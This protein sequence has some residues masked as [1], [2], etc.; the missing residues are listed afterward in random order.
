VRVAHAVVGVVVGGGW[1]ALPVMTVGAGDPVPAAPDRPVASSA[2]P[3][4][5]GTSAT[6]LLLPIAVVGAAGVLA[7]YGYVRRTRRARTRTTPGLV[8]TAPPVH[9]PADSERQAGAALVLADDCVRG[10]RE[11]LSFVEGLFGEERA[12]PFR[13]A[14]RAAETELAAAFAIWGRYEEG[15]PGDASARRQALVGVVGRCTEAGRRLDSEAEALDRLRDLEEGVGEALG[16]AEGR[17]RELTARTAA[18]QL[19]AS[20][21]HDRYG[22]SAAEPVIGSVEQAKDRLVFATSQLNEARQADDTHDGRR[23]A[24]HLRAAEGAIAQVGVLVGGVERLAA[25]L[26]EAAEMVPAALTGAESEAAAARKGDVP[27]SLTAGELHARLAHADGVLSAVR[28]EL[29]AGPYDPLDALRRI[30]RAA[31]RLEVGRSGVIEAAALLVARSTVGEAEDY[32]AVHRGAVGAEARTRLAKA[33]R[34][35]DGDAVA[36]TPA[37][38]GTTG[39]SLH[40]PP[41]H[42]TE[43]DTLA[44]QARELAERDVRTHGNP[45]A[46]SEPLPAGLPGAVLGGILLAED[47]DAG[48]PTS[49]GGPRTRNRHHDLP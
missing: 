13:H 37:P 25:E 45:Y 46:A 33:V 49:F 11:E 48:P 3:E 18:A 44:R 22:P 1:L 8:P 29:T 43:A 30:A 4:H 40:E 7:G 14:V 38:G 27:I 12:E 21:L 28:E 9:S 16:V 6:D 23:A 42:A 47:P 32:L 20:A 34:A 35:L 31:E 2:A 39:I 26:R 10:S 41:G 15:I 24:R 19:T 17:F 36:G 5:D